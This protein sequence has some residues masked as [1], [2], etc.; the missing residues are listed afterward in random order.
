MNTLYLAGATVKPRISGARF[1]DVFIDVPI[2]DGTPAPM[3]PTFETSEWI[4]CQASYYRSLGSDL[5]DLLADRIEDLARC[6]RVLSQG[7]PI[8][9]E[10]FIAREEVMQ[11]LASNNDYA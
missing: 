6:W 1:D 5:A 11:E 9:V 7:L 4:D 2:D 3:V 10:E 8:S